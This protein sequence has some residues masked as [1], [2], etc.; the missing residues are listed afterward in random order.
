MIFLLKFP[1]L[2]F[3][4]CSIHSPPHFLAAGANSTPPL[5]A[6]MYTY[7]LM[8][9]TDDT[10]SFRNSESRTVVVGL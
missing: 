2:T 9:S 1:R 6:N 8:K 7:S 3:F 4:T 10:K 5:N